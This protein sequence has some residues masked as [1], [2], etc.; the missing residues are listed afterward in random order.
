LDFAGAKMKHV[1]AALM[2]LFVFDPRLG[3]TEETEHE[4]ILF[5]YPSNT[6][7]NQQQSDV[8]LSEA[9]IAF[10]RCV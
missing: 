6:P 5:Y 10:T 9:L 7:L 8:G 2:K 4:K 3:V 1:D